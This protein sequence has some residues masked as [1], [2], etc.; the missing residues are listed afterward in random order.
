M[1]MFKHTFL[2]RLFKA[3]KLLFAA[4]SLYIL[5]V[6]YYTRWQREEF[7]F[8]LYGMYSLKE[9]PQQTYT[10]YAIE[11]DSQQVKYSKLRDA[12]RELINSTLTQVVPMIDSGRIKEQDLALYKSWLMN[13]TADM[14]LL[15]DNKMHVYKL[16]CNY[17]EHGHAGILKKELVY[18]YGE[19]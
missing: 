5:G 18:T 12:Q 2:Y 3:D 6:L 10:A 1:N 15:G 16:T 17:D 7:P 19:E 14:R 4:I 8:F 13:Y 9:L 11:L